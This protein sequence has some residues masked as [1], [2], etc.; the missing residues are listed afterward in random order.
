MSEHSEISP[1]GLHRVLNCPGSVRQ[2]RGLESKSSTYSM[3]GSIVHELNKVC[4]LRGHDAEE[5]LGYWGW[6]NKNNAT[7]I[8]EAK[9][10]EKSVPRFI[11]ITEK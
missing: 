4:L 10:A 5:Y 11:Q 2:C 7:G 6:Y 3:D 8:Q 1:S 9:P